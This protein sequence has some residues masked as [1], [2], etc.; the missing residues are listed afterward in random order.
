[1]IPLMVRIGYKP[2]VAAGIESAAS[3]GGALMPPVMGAAAFVMAEMTNIP[4]GDII[5]AAA[6]GAVLYYFAILAAVHFEAKK[7]GITPMAAKDIP[8][9]REVLADAHLILPIGL[10]VYLMNERWSGN[11]AAFCATLAMV[12]ASLLRARTRMGWRA[13][14]ESLTNAGLTMAP[15][16][17]SIAASGVVVSVLTATGMVVAFGGIIKEMSGGSLGLLLVLLCVT[18]LV[19]GLGI[20]TTPS[21]IIAAAIGVPQVLELG[22]P[23]GIDMMQAH[24]FIFY[25]AVIA[26][27]TPPVAAA[28]FAAAAIAKASPTIASIHASRFGIAGFT[29]GFAFIYDPGIMLRGS[30]FEIVSATAVQVVALV[31]V[32]SAYAGFLLRP[33]GGPLRILLAAAGLFAAFG[34]IAP[35]S[36]RLPLAAAALG[37]TAL[38]QLM[39]ARKGGTI[40]PVALLCGPLLAAPAMAQPAGPW[41]AAG[42]D[43]PARTS[44]PP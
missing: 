22:R 29:V 40:L 7:L 37:A 11:Y 30:L 9:W 31:L 32:T 16:A 6:I 33:M 25:F 39:T 2:A 21:Y 28:A 14:L 26:D 10:L 24:L 19:L 5:V 38:L 27:A 3:V 8:A 23:L 35:D 12:A 41:A 1:T 36:V 34:H 44:P 15:L 43:V 18:V 20:P 13:I 4:Y 42:I 17:V